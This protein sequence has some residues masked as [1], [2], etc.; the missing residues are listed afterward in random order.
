M[1]TALHTIVGLFYYLCSMKRYSKEIYITIIAI[2]LNTFVLDS[3]PEVGRVISGA[4]RRCLTLT[5]FFIGSSLS[6]DV[7]KTVGIMPLIQGIF[8]WILISAGS[9]LYIILI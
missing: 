2:L 1:F 3:V 9:L 8:L 5:M 6:T 7:L 4:A